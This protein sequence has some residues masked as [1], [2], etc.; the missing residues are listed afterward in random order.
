LKRKLFNYSELYI[1]IIK[2]YDSTVYYKAKN[3]SEKTKLIIYKNSLI[4]VGNAIKK[5]FD[6]KRY[7]NNID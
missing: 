4:A 7:F 5:Y 1:N 3:Y 6:N 2:F